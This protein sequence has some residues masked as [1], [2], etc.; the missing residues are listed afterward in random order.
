MAISEKLKSLVARM[1]DADGRGMYTQNIDKEKTESAVAEIAKGGRAD[2][3]GLVEML[4][5]PGADENV[6]P[7]Y[8]LHCVVNYALIAGDEPMR[9]DVCGLLAAKLSDAAVSTYNKAFLCQELQ[10]AGGAEAVGAL[11]KLL[12]DDELTDPAAAA[13]TAIGTGAGDQFRAA[14]SGA[15]GECRLAVIQALGAVE[16]TPSIG[17]LREALADADREIR[18]AAGWGLAR[19]GD[20]GSVDVLLKAADVEPG[21]ERIQATKHCLVLAEKLQESGEK[22]RAEQIF[23]HL[24]DSRSDPSERYVRDAAE[25]ALAGA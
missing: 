21:W 17:T 16:D 25:K 3:E 13:L 10:W 1:P 12:T 14:V 20:A 5:A 7:H 15:K 2:V 18:L 8:A 24:R 23:Q 9:K 19:M 22:A 6:K 11:G 4:G